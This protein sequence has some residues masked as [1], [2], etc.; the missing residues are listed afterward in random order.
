V[1]R[2]EISEE[3][4]KEVRTLEMDRNGNRVDDQ[5]REKHRHHAGSDRSDDLKVYPNPSSGELNIT[6]KLEDDEP[7]T[8]TI[9]NEAGKTVFKK[10]YKEAGEYTEVI[11][12][13]ENK[14]GIFVVNL[15]QKRRSI[16]KKII[17]E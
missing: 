10:E 17:V 5:R 14:R 1:I 3:N 6:L 8:L 16:S 9:Q 4:G 11:E 13:K 12:I 7:A 2:I 15:N